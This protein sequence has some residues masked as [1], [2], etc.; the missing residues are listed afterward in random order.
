MQFLRNRKARAPQLLADAQLCDHVTV[1]VRI[2]LLEV[3]QKTAALADQHQKSAAGAMVLLVRFEVL[4]QLANTLAQNRDLDLGTAR[5]RFMRTEFGDDVCF[6]CG[7][8]HGSYVLLILFSLVHF[9][10][11]PIKFSTVTS[12]SR[13][14]T[15]IPKTLRNFAHSA[16]FA[17]KPLP[18]PAPT[19]RSP[20][21]TPASVPVPAW[22]PPR[23][24]A[25]GRHR[26]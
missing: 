11:C 12:Q 18:L 14:R 22:P 13:P 9:S 10:Q 15:T 7:C 23:C 5:V 21:K 26:G 1:A 4:G 24:S 20:S 16:N 8:Q 25:P 6:L 19:P 2:S 17:S 3:I